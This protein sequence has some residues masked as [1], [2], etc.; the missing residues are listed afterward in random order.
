MVADVDSYYR[1]I[2]FVS[3]SRVIEHTGPR[4]S[5]TS[6]E[7]RPWL[8]D[9]GKPGE[10]HKL[11]H[12]MQ[13]A[14]MGFDQSWKSYV[15]CEKYNVVSAYASSSTLFKTLSTTWTFTPSP[16]DVPHLSNS[17]S[18]PHAS[19]PLSSPGQSQSDQSTPAGQSAKD[20]NAD[21]PST[22]P[23]LVSIDLAYEFANPLYAA[24]ASGSIEK[25]SAKIMDAFEKRVREVYGD[26]VK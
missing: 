26:G 4:S 9:S 16:T 1:F 10:V 24:A 11:D 8:D 13:I 20:G 25:V 14:I 22:T 7:D 19:A 18:L 5:E 21:S 23:T 17:Q 15:T 2:P 12:I 6:L 3:S